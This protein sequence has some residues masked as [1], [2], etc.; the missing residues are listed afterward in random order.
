[1]R[2]AAVLSLST[3][4]HHKPRLLA[5]QLPPLLPKLYAQTAVDE[6]LIR[7][8]DLGP[9]KHRIDDGLEL[10]KVVA[11][12]EQCSPVLLPLLPQTSCSACMQ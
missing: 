1:V 8:V 10:R 9:F 12:P 3:L 2:K 4:A 5:G 7:V 6:S 11:W